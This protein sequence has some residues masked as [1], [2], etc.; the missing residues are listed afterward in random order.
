MAFSLTHLVNSSAYDGAN[1]TTYNGAPFQ[2]LTIGNAPSSGETRSVYVVIGARSSTSG[3][4][5]SST[6]LTPSGESAIN[7][8][9]VQ[10]AVATSA[11]SDLCEIWCFED[12]P[13]GTV[14]DLS[15]TFN[16]SMLRCGAHL[17]R[18]IDASHVFDTATDAV[19]SG[20]DLSASLDIPSG[21]GAIGGCWA[22]DGAVSWT[23]I[24]EVAEF[25]PEGAFL[26]RISAALDN[27]GTAY[28]GRTITA[29]IGIIAYRGSMVVV[30]IAP[31]L[32]GEASPT[33]GALTGAATGALLLSGSVDK[34]LG[35]LIAEGNG[36][37]ATSGQASATLGE[38][39]LSSSGNIQLSGSS[40][41]TLGSVT[42]A[43]TGVLQVQGALTKQ[44]DALSGS[45]SSEI[46]VSGS[47]NATLGSLVCAA[48]GSLALAGSVS[49]TLGSLSSLSE[50]VIIASGTGQ[51][52]ATLGA[53]LC[54]AA[55]VIGVSGSVVVTLGA[56]SSDAVGGTSESGGAAILYPVLARRRKRR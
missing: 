52:D 46:A 28:T 9:L 11:G 42:G 27:S 16:G 47:E 14:A 10:Y 26:G 32:S 38:L 48:S 18:A 23:N 31:K 30:S 29:T 19:L 15:V 33:L 1:A 37:T 20:S 53:L 7:G 44:L 34:T 22:V 8:V 41:A 2:S 39:T 45:S 4:R 56:L 17:F 40:N 55:G 3:R 25:E 36:A 50:G 54:E 51:T 43:S 24:T 13:S 12:V 5:V 21:G 49:K 35:A 6:T